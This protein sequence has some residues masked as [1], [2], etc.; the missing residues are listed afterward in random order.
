MLAN[1]A[2]RYGTNILDG[3]E[4]ESMESKSLAWQERPEIRIRSSCCPSCGTQLAEAGGIA[5]RKSPGAND[6]SICKQCGEIVV[7]AASDEGLTLRATTASEYLS[8]SEDAQS[9]LRVAH[10]LVNAQIRHRNC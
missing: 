1:Y 2:A 6:V 4:M 3:G 7:L 5:G 10:V 8:L 9:L